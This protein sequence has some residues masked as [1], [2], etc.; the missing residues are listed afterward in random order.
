MFTKLL[1][2]IITIMMPITYVEYLLCGR[3]CPSTLILSTHLTPTTTL[4]GRYYN[5]FNFADEG[6]LLIILSSLLLNSLMQ[7]FCPAVALHGWQSAEGQALMC[8]VVPGPVGSGPSRHQTVNHW[9]LGHWQ[10]WNPMFLL[11]HGY[12][13][14]FSILPAYSGLCLSDQLFLS[15]AV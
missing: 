3:T 9:T 1:Q 12:G 15:L 14:P 13:V 4:R 5:Y 6:R 11:S 8:L 7:H 10:H 2:V